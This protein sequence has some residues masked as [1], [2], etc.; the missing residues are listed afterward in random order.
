[1]SGKHALPVTLNHTRRCTDG[2]A[3]MSY[4][5]ADS[6]IGFEWTGSYEDPVEVSVGGLGEPITH[7]I[8]GTPNGRQDLRQYFTSSPYIYEAVGQVHT[9]QDLCRTWLV[10][11]TL[12]GPWATEPTRVNEVRHG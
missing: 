9:F 8:T 3:Y 12:P 1:M 7:I 5:D 11:M 4:F 2:K 10:A 6:Q